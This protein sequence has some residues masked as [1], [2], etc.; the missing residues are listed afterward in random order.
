M[1]R[2]E[3]T[4][5]IATE[6]VESSN[7]IKLPKV[8][9]R[10]KAS[11]TRVLDSRNRPVKFLQIRGDR[12]YAFFKV[13]GGD[14][15]KKP[16]RF[17]LHHEDGTPVANLTEAGE[18]LAC[19]RVARQEHV[20]PTSGRKP[21]FSD[22]AATYLQKAAFLAKKPGTRT[23]EEKVIAL[24]KS[25]FGSTRVDNIT[26][27]MIVAFQELRRKGTF[28]ARGKT[29][30]PITART[31]NLDVITLRN[32][33]NA[34]KDDGHLR[35]L[36]VV[37]KLKEVEA[38]EKRLLTE[39]EFKSLLA[40]CLTACQRN[41]AQLADY[42]RFLAYSGAREQ[43]ALHIKWEDV[44][45]PDE[46]L[47]IGADKDTKNHKSRSVNFTAPLREVL[48]EMHSR[49]APDSVWLFPSPRRGDK[50]I[51]ASSLKQSLDLARTAADLPWVGFH[52]LRHYFCSWCV[53]SGIDFMTV[54][55][56]AG[57]SDGGI[58]IGKVY[59]HLADEHKKAAA[60]RVSFGLRV[61]STPKQE[62]G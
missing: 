33:L 48:L 47:T 18:A 43:E 19:L 32:V 40:H 46:K 42:L 41:G 61:L 20:L 39:A 36:P 60:A 31:A 37:K 56:W 7:R 2:P 51:R 35:A 30:K 50:D 5:D 16:R 45:F 11:F 25:H 13:D 27:A 12:Y 29:Y 8:A 24:W 17:P 28:V 23:N 10:H 58:L 59:G 44:N 53:M 52:H 6:A 3:S 57:H 49:R 22:Y 21:A 1:K 54:A 4:V 34:A 9:R 15:T 62:V 14:G 38:V 26:T 55:S